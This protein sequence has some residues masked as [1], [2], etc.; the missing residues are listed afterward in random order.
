MSDGAAAAGGVNHI[1]ASAD[2]TSRVSPSLLTQGCRADT[3]SRFSLTPSVWGRVH[4]RVPRVEQVPASRSVCAGPPPPHPLPPSSPGL[5]DAGDCPKGHE[6]QIIQ[7]HSEPE[8]VPSSGEGRSDGQGFGGSL[9]PPRTC[10]LSIAPWDR[11][12]RAR[13][14]GACAGNSLQETN[15]KGH[16][17]TGPLRAI[18]DATVAQTPFRLAPG[19]GSGVCPAERPLRLGVVQLVGTGGPGHSQKPRPS[20]RSCDTG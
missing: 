8:T 4:A 5:G 1:R 2:A 14:G 6:T 16:V 7:S 15:Q 19:G 17:H 18:V 9:S 3:R 11:T 10:A 20:F 12:P 13:E